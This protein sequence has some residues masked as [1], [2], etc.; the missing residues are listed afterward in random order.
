[1]KKIVSMILLAL[2]LFPTVCLGGICEHDMQV[3]GEIPPTCTSIGWRHY[4]CALCG[5]DGG[6]VLLP[7]LGHECGA[8]ETAAAPTCTQAGTEWRA[9]GRCGAT[10]ERTAGAALGHDWAMTER[11]EPTEDAEG[12]ETWVCRNDGNHLH[13]VVIAKLERMPEPEQQG[14][15]EQQEPEPEDA[16]DCDD[17][18]HLWGE[19]ENVREPRCVQVGCRKRVCKRDASHAETEAIPATGQHDWSAWKL[20]TPGTATQRA[21]YERHCRACGK[22][23]Y[24]YGEYAEKK[25]VQENVLESLLRAVL[26]FVRR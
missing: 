14:E 10:E 18:G 4:V 17:L 21:M 8:W 9:C 2:M 25:P 19:W 26:R 24:K 15:P 3:N 7:A 5:A 23:E 11:I 12:R 6:A 1:M 22:E 13:Y 16:P 20:E